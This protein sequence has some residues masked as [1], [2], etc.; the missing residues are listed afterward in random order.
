MD[1]DGKP[2]NFYLVLRPCGRKITLTL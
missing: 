2:R 1:G